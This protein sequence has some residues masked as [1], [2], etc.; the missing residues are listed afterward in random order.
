MASG[1]TKISAGSLNSGMWVR[2][3]NRR[4]TEIGPEWVKVHEVHPADVEE[5]KAGYRVIL[6]S[7]HQYGHFPA[8]ARFELGSEPAPKPEKAPKPARAPREP[9]PTTPKV[10]VAVRAAMATIAK[11]DGSLTRGEFGHVD[12]MVLVAM[13]QRGWATVSREGK[14][15]KVDLV[16]WTDAGWEAARQLGLVERQPADA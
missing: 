6:E 16:E 15:R 2:L 5:G 12:P 13:E 9:K 11:H 4:G 14:E 3:A 7:G 1:A 10:S 8:S